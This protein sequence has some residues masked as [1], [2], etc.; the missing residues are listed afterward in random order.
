MLDRSLGFL[1]LA[2]LAPDPAPGFLEILNSGSGKWLAIA[3]RYP[4]L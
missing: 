4:E 2:V 3:N 1:P